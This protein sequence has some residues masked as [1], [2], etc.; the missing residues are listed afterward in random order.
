METE[1]TAAIRSRQLRPGEQSYRHVL[2]ATDGSAL[3]ERAVA[4]GLRLAHALGARVTALVVEAPFSIHD[5]P[6]SLKQTPEALGQ[7]AELGRKHATQVLER[8]AE[9]AKAA[10]VACDTLQTEHSQPSE[11]ILAT[12]KAKGCDLI[13]VASHGRRGIPAAV[14]GSVT[15]H[16]LTHSSVPVLVCR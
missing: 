9:A 16:V 5:L 10:G 8:V 11:A 2:I 14:L 7:H 3:A 6:D 12:A 1:M 15:N 4:H 13:V